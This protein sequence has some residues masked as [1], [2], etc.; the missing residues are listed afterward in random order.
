MAVPSRRAKVCFV[1]PK[2]RPPRDD[3]ISVMETFASHIAVCRICLTT[4][5]H[6]RNI[7]LCSDGYGYA[8]DVRQYLYLRGSKV[9]SVAD[10]RRNK[11]EVEVEVPRQYDAIFGILSKKHIS[12]SASQSTPR[13][14]R[15]RLPHSMPS[16]SKTSHYSDCTKSPTSRHI[17]TEEFYSIYVTIPSITLP[18]R[19]RRSEERD[20][21]G[22]NTWSSYCR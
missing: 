5:D 4:K 16:R 15:Y 14:Q 22:N 3:E 19:I 17:K 21:Y 1:G 11:G 2:P 7:Y 6:T 18:L 12:S 8:M 20:V 9:I 10:C 13:V